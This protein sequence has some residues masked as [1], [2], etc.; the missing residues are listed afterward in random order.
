MEGPAPEP[1]DWQFPSAGWHTAPVAESDEQLLA[2]WR[3][4]LTTLRGFEGQVLDPV[5]RQTQRELRTQLE[6]AEA[7]LDRRGLRA[8]APVQPGPWQP[9]PLHDR[10]TAGPAAATVEPTWE[11]PDELVPVSLVRFIAD[12]P[13]DLP[14]D[15]ES[16]S[17]RLEWQRELE[18]PRNARPTSL[19]LR[20]RRQPPFI[21]DLDDGLTGE[22]R[23]VIER[24]ARAPL[25]APQVT[26]ALPHGL[27]EALEQLRRPRRYP[28][29]VERDGQFDLTELARAMTSLDGDRPRVHGG[30]FPNL[31]ANGV[32]D[33]LTFPTFDV[34]R[35][36]NAASLELMHPGTPATNV[37]HA[38]GHP[39]VGPGFEV[40][41]TSKTFGAR[42]RGTLCL[43]VKPLQWSRTK[44]L[45]FRFATE[46]DAARALRQ[47]DDAHA[48]AEFHAG[49]EPAVEHSTLSVV[50]PPGVHGVRVLSR[51]YLDR[52]LESWWRVEL[53]ARG[54]DGVRART[55]PEV[56]AHFVARSR[57]E[58]VRRLR[59]QKLPADH[60]LEVVDALLRVADDERLAALIDAA[61]SKDEAV[62][63]L[64]H[65]DSTELAMHQRLGPFALRAEPFTGAQARAVV[66]TV[67]LHLKRQMLA[68]ER[69]A[70]AQE[71]SERLA[72]D[73]P[74]EV[75]RQLLAEFVRVAELARRHEREGD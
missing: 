41:R 53:K 5:D 14:L 75:E 58:L 26:A 7:E 55:L 44:R 24:L 71:M 56:V 63:A 15:G 61:A 69:D 10:P 60:R 20:H 29:L 48:R 12:L 72:P 70:L 31:L 8:G 4:T 6:R 40:I 42:P 25:P 74:D 16:A 21:P 73:R 59:R 35:I 49:T 67:G 66:G 50:L 62:W 57:V 54:D 32:G 28:L 36:L 38:C 27:A 13:D 22:Q 11:P 19:P 65:L 39:S 3:E 33:G 43:R 9:L 47:L 45:E 1:I 34:S 2:R 52:S 68:L 37:V 64:T 23:L 46:A 18:Q 30:F 17:A 51:L